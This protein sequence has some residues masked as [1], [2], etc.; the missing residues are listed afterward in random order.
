M[1][2]RTLTDA[3]LPSAWFHDDARPPEDNRGPHVLIVDDF[4]PD[5]D[6]VRALGLSHEFVQFT[7]PLAEQVGAET[8]SLPEFESIQGTWRSTA[9][10]RFRGRKVDRPFLGFRHNP[11]SLRQTLEGLTGESIRTE[12]WELG[13]DGWNGA[14]HLRDG[15]HT[16]ASIHH[17]YK[18]G[19][20]HPRGWSGLVYLTPDPPEDSGTSFWRDKESGKCIARAGVVAT[21]DFDRF[22]RVFASENRYNRLVLFRENVLHRAEPG[23]GR[24]EGARLTQTFFFISR[25]RS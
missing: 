1:R 5:P 15:G 3:D 7:P 2:I 11:E 17:H 22:E 16:K 25:P 12:S 8:A 6:R 24:N 4:Y 10:L 21:K 19:D 9:L 13:G 23:F 18:E 20:V 14:F